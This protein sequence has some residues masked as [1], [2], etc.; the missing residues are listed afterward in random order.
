MPRKK[1]VKK[2]WQ[3]RVSATVFW[4]VLAIIL[5]LS[6]FLIGN[7]YSILLLSRQ[8]EADLTAIATAS[9]TP[10]NTEISI[11]P[12]SATVA[13]L[14]PSEQAPE[15]LSSFG[16][17][18]SGL[19]YIDRTTTDLFWDENITAFTFPPVYEAVK[20]NDCSEPFC[21]LSFESAEPASVC[22]KN[23]CLHKTDDNRLL[24]NERE[25][26][27]PPALA[28]QEIS[29][30]TIYALD[31]YWLIG[32]VTGPT[33]AE[34]GWVYRFDG[35]AYSPLITDTTD[36]QILP[37]YQRGG[38]KIAFGGTADDFLVL[39]A[40]Y[41]GRAFRFRGSAVEDVSKFF[42]LRVTGGGFR[43]QILKAGTGK[44]AVFY[45]CSL[46]ETKPKLIKIWSQDDL[47]SGGALDFSPLLFK[48]DW[49]PQQIICAFSDAAKNELAIASKTNESS[50]L[51]RVT[52]NGFDNSRARQ[53]TSI[54]LNRQDK[55]T[56]KA[57]VLAD[58]GLETATGSAGTTAY[59][60]NSAGQFEIVQ[61]YLW[62][63]FEQAG[64]ELYWR[65]VL[66]PADDNSHSPWFDHVNRLDYLFKD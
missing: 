5:F 14:T 51:Y 30:L 6:I 59:L 22:L 37:R 28:G 7:L 66:A 15:R 34:R 2:W 43:P 38:G 44:D 27:L 16:D 13:V 60:A 24:Y 26:K 53:A 64:A 42:G 48:D 8:A 47:R 12:D 41:D 20:Q 21:G 55:E 45:I 62:H 23:N 35:L 19:S 29:S 39:Y 1:P 46:T 50:E 36:S 31:D 52:D 58:F 63:N 11:N 56:I 10:L 3:R 61:P 25:L 57:A 33:E 32:L 4:S 65:L 54:N 49:Q 9:T 40:G 17:S 18:F